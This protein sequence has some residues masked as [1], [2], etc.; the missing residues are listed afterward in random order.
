MEGGAR[1]EG[2]EG[3]EKETKS[4]TEFVPKP[5]LLKEAVM[6]GKGTGCGATWPMDNE[7][8]TNKRE[9]IKRRNWNSWREKIEE[10]RSR[11]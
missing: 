10:T 6:V 5:L 1:L 11:E 8:G 9:S 3:E 4:C 2:R 7:S